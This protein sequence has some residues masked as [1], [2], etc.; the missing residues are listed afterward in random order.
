M[1]EKKNPKA[2][3]QTSREID[4]LVIS[5]AEITPLG[6]PRLKCGGTN[7]VRSP[8]L[9]TSLKGQRSLLVSTMPPESKSGWQ[10]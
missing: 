9:R 4:D 3:K 7:L 10:G 5:Q 8:S 6:E 2:R 1:N